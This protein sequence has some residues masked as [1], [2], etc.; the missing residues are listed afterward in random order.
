MAIDDDFMERVAEYMRQ[1]RLTE[2]ALKELSAGL[3]DLDDKRFARVLVHFSLPSSIARFK[4]I[5]HHKHRMRDFGHDVERLE[6]AIDSHN[7]LRKVRFW[8]VYDD[9]ADVWNVDFVR[10]IIV[11]N[12]DGKT[13]QTQKLHSA[14]GKNLPSALEAAIAAVPHVVTLV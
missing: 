10:S 3:T 12:S 4:E 8:L 11:P 6:T 13:H 14:T 9:K 7:E 2:A 5:V 1:N